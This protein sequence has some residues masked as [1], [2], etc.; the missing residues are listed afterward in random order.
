MDSKIN[1]Q[2]QMEDIITKLAQDGRTGE[3]APTILLHSCCAPCSTSVIS[4]LSAFF[5]IT[6]YYYNPNI[7][8]RS[9]YEKRAREQERLIKMI[10]APHPVS[11]LEG[12]YRPEDY[13]AVA[14]PFAAEK[15]G[16][17]R[18]TACYTLRL[19]KTAWEA[20]QKG[21]DF[22]CTT[23]SV[24]PLKDARRINEI[25]NALEQT[26]G[27]SWLWSDFKKKNGYLCSI[28]LSEEYG[29]YRQD[30]CGCSFSKLQRDRER[31]TGM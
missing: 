11:F 2:K 12:D 1:Y 6:V 21:F 3:N 8:E 29:L 4:V 5:R 26:Y 13:L 10:N 9:E 27:V 28:R 17:A 22:F 24:S 30:Y 20:A 31:R 15:E 14:K 18:C 25:G 7:D 16:G 23:L 19:D